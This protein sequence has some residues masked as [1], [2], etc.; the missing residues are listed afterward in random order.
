M[1]ARRSRS[2]SAIS[3]SDG[4]CACAATA[5]VETRMTH[6]IATRRL[7]IQV[8]SHRAIPMLPQVPAREGCEPHMDGTLTAATIPAIATTIMISTAVNPASVCP[9]LLTGKSNGSANESPTSRG[10]DKCNLLNEITW[11]SGPPSSLARVRIRLHPYSS[12]LE[13]L[14]PCLFDEASVVRW[15]VA[16]FHDPTRACILPACFFLC[17]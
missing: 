12:A 14:F 11:S 10:S 15:A 13:G 17:L 6:P 3:A 2:R 8:Y 5:H 16:R 1:V 7:T 9:I 4:G